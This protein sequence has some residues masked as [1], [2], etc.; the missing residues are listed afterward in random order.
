[1]HFVCKCGLCKEAK[2]NKK[3]EKQKPKKLQRKISRKCCASFFH[4][5]TH[6]GRYQGRE[7]QSGQAHPQRGC[8]SDPRQY[9]ESWY[10]GGHSPLPAGS[11]AQKNQPRSHP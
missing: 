7:L 1:M 8:H 11:L 3:R 10:A 4:S 6:D 5:T 2:R 9:A